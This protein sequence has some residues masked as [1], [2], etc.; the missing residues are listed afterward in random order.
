MLVSVR[1]LVFVRVLVLVRVS[2]CASCVYVCECLCLFVC[3]LVCLF[4]CLFFAG[5]CDV[6]RR[7]FPVSIFFFPDTCFLDSCFP[8]VCLFP[9][10]VV[11]FS[12]VYF[13]SDV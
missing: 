1:V 9:S 6:L 5:C 7:C 2:V 10:F 12:D 3:F 13:S 11:C 4:V 8:G